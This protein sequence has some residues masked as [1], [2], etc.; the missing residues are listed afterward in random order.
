[1]NHDREEIIAANPLLDYCQAQ[2]GNS[3]K[4][5]LAGNACVRCTT[6][7]HR[8]SRSIPRRAFGTVLAA[9]PEAASSTCTPNCG[10]SRSVR[11]CGI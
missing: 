11:Q 3:R 4:T 1:M 8:A 2:V 7:T 10:V 9:I 6:K 5:V